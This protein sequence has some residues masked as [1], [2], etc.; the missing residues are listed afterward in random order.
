MPP[1]PLGLM[2]YPTVSAESYARL[3][4]VPKTSSRRPEYARHG[5]FMAKEK[6]VR[7]TLF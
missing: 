7:K 4:R 3:Q 1:H 5:Q 6:S 2:P